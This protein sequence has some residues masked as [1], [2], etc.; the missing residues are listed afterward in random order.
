MIVL[1]KHW[2]I[3]LHNSAQ[4]TLEDVVKMKIVLGDGEESVTDRKSQKE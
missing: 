3:A 4:E 1:G 2:F